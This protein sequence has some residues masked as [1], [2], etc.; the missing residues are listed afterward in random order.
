MHLNLVVSS[1]RA[2]IFGTQ[3]QEEVCNADFPVCVLN[4][5][6]EALTG[7]HTGIHAKIKASKL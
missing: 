6:N 7:H 4:G 5:S 2:G 1:E 3:E